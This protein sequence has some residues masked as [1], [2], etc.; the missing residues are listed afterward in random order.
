MDGGE[1]STEAALNDQG[2]VAS[3]TIIRPQTLL[4][5]HATYRSGI[6]YQ[7]SVTTKSAHEIE[8]KMDVDGLLSVDIY[9]PRTLVS[10]IP[11]KNESV[12]VENFP[13]FEVVQ[14]NKSE[15]ILCVV[16]RTSEGLKNEFLVFKRRE[17]M[18]L[19]I[20]KL[21][22][23]LFPG[24]KRSVR[25]DTDPTVNRHSPN[26]KR[27]QKTASAVE[28]C[29]GGRSESSTSVVAEYSENF[30]FRVLEAEHCQSHNTDSHGFVMVESTR[31]STES[32]F[33]C[34]K[35][36][37]ED[38]YPFQ[39]DDPSSYGPVDLER[40]NFISEELL[41]AHQ[42][43]SPSISTLYSAGESSQMARLGHTPIALRMSPPENNSSRDVFS[44]L[45]QE[46]GQSEVTVSVQMEDALT[47]K[48]Y[49]HLDKLWIKSNDSSSRLF[50]GD[51]I[52]M[53]DDVEVTEESAAKSILLAS[54]QTQIKFTIARLPHSHLLLIDNPRSEEPPFMSEGTKIKWINVDHDIGLYEAVKNGKNYITHINTLHIPF[55]AG[56]TEIISLL[57]HAGDEFFLILHP[58]DVAEKLG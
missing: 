42:N 43:R 58:K 10:S 14:S 40:S 21:N 52:K 4:K 30:P 41:N 46:K 38:D 24:K 1:Q 25:R 8:L 53:I 19:W 12:A 31:D 2:D 9:S 15:N 51:L 27:A 33:R 32:R 34:T 50:G 47:L 55:G 5:S 16:H 36:P 18:Q 39:D 13:T 23:T 56:T 20:D 7:S 44:Q 17:E 54:K 49:T 29:F 48:F 26:T 35:T 37:V 6:S 57:Q 22:S 3:P 45:C 28:E 11:L